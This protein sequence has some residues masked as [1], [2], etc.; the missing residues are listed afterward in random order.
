[1]AFYMWRV[2]RSKKLRH[3]VLKGMTWPCFCP[4]DTGSSVEEG[5]ERLWVKSGQRLP[6]NS[7]FQTRKGWQLCELN[8]IVTA[9]S[10]TAC[11]K[12]RNDLKNK[13]KKQPAKQTKNLALRNGPKVTLLTKKKTGVLQMVTFQKKKINILQWRNFLFLFLQCG[14]ISANSHAVITSCNSNISSIKYSL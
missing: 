9:C 14:C 5:K 3:S 6:V 12:S 13:H 10:W 8:E 1:M 2:R 4:Q 11:V 7:I